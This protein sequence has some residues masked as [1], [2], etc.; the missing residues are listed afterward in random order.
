MNLLVL[1]LLAAATN[2]QPANNSGNAT[3]T[4]KNST[5][6]TPSKPSVKSKTSKTT[7]AAQTDVAGNPIPTTEFRERSHPQPPVYFVTGRCPQPLRQT[8]LQRDVRKAS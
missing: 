1:A 5:T 6:N 3:T 4:N 2:T 8:S 7:A